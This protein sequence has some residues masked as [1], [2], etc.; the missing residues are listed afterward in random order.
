VLRRDWNCDV[1]PSD[2]AIAITLPLPP[3]SPVVVSMAVASVR[4][5]IGLRVWRHWSVAARPRRTSISATP[6]P[7]AYR[8][9]LMAFRRCGETRQASMSGFA[10]AAAEA[11][12]SSRLYDWLVVV[13]RAR[14][15]KRISPVS[16]NWTSRQGKNETNTS[17]LSSLLSMRLAVPLRHSTTITGVLFNYK[18]LVHDFD[19]LRYVHYC[20]KEKK[21]PTNKWWHY[22]VSIKLWTYWTTVSDCY[23]LYLLF[24]IFNLNSV[25]QTWK[26]SLQS[27][28]TCLLCSILKHTLHR[29]FLHR[30]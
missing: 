20:V 27:N 7:T 25:L 12:A 24:Y 2:V 11:E 4:N 9:I 19:R 22:V 8:S 14:K 5:A 28:C 3:P 13:V 17:V 29:I 30:S 16:S 10:L 18:R 1:H 15:L 21:T 23:I 6:P 26:K